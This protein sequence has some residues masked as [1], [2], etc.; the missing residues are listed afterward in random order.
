LTDLSPASPLVDLRGV[1]PLRAEALARAGFRTVADL[2]FHLPYRY[3]DRRRR[4]RISE[5]DRTGMAMLQGR[6][7]DL[8]R[9]RVRRRNLALVRGRFVDET[10]DLEAIW[11]NQP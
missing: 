6:V 11:F 9:V 5:I 1:G 7:V 8:R 10:G 4:L 2:L 3:E